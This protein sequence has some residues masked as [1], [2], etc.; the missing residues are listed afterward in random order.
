MEGGVG[1]KHSFWAAASAEQQVEEQPGDLTKALPHITGTT[2]D[3]LVLKPGKLEDCT[4]GVPCIFSS[5]GADSREEFIKAPRG[6]AWFEVLVPAGS[7]P[8]VEDRQDTEYPIVEWVL[9]VLPLGRKAALAWQAALGQGVPCSMALS[10]FAS[11]WAAN[12][13]MQPSS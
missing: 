13:E 12:G 4:G 2:C 7:P 6:D 8:P 11:C 1:L 10:R 3:V 9:A 5:I